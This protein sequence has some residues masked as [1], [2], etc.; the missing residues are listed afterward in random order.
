[1]GIKYVLQPGRINI[2]SRSNNHSL[3]SL[4]KIHESVFIHLAQITG[5]K[6][7]ITVIVFSQCFGGFFFIITVTY[8]Y[9]RTVNTYLS[10]FIVRNFLC[11]PHF[12]YLIIC[13]GIRDSYTSLFIEVLRSK[14]T[15][16]NTLGG[17]VSFPHLNIAA[18]FFQKLVQ[19]SLK[20][21]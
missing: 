5:M 17:T 2:I 11:C 13:V 14:T 20:L 19:L 1:M 18:V 16:G 12:D 10:F 4:R 3:Y 9:R 15:C 8:H 7:Y 21:D 6:P